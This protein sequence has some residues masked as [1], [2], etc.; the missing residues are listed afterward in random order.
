MPAGRLVPAGAF[1]V[2]SVVGLLTGTATP[3][4]LLSV[5]SRAVV[6]WLTYASGRVPGDTADAVGTYRMGEPISDYRLRRLLVG[7]YDGVFVV[8]D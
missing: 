6:V 4:Q 1:L 5:S 8:G 7:A 3:W 2:G